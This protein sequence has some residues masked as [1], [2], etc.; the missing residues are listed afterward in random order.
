ML[1][2]LIELYQNLA[3]DKTKIVVGNPPN[4]KEVKNFD[5][6]SVF[7]TNTLESLYYANV[8]GE[9]WMPKGSSTHRKNP[10]HEDQEPAL[11]CIF[12]T[13]GY[14]APLDILSKMFLENKVS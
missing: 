6:A 13:R 4:I 3:N 9:V 11:C 7:P 12:G 10:F 1:T 14:D 2:K 5:V 8:T